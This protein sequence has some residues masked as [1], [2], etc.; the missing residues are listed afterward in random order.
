MKCPNCPM[1]LSEQGGKYHCEVC[2]WFENV[3][4]DWHVCEA[5]ESIPAPEPE[6][7]PVLE[8]EPGPGLEPVE[9]ESGPAPEPESQV[10]KYL[11]G[12]VTIT[13]VVYE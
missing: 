3:D 4:G 5:P 6:P 13:E 11:G 8:T 2:G 12:I 10:K 7:E 9:Q 1:S